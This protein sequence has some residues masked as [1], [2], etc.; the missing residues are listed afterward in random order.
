MASCI[1]TI[2]KRKNVFSKQWPS[3]QFSFLAFF[4]CLLDLAGQV[5]S[6]MRGK[7]FGPGTATDQVCVGDLIS[8]NLNF[9]ICKMGI[10]LSINLLHG[11]I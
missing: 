3:A 6:K 7:D 11:I 2:R 10:T 4:F 1:Y 8:S 9:L 5:R